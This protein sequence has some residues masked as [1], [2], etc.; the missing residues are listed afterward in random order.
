MNYILVYDLGTS[1]NKASLFSVE[2]RMVKSVVVSYET[3]YLDEISVEQN[4]DDWWKSVIEATKL[5]VAD[6]NVE[7][8]KVISVSGHMQGMVLL[9]D[10]GDL[11]YNSLIWMDQRS[12]KQTKELES[13]ISAERIREITNGGVSP[14][15]TLEKLMWM[16]DEKPEIYKRISKVLNTKDYITYKLTGALVTDFSDGSGTGV[17]DIFNGCWSQEILDVVDIPI[18]IFPELHESIDVVGHVTKEAGEAC[19]IMSGI[20]VVCGG[21]DGACATLGA[22]SIKHGDTYC[23]M[24]SSAQIAITSDFLIVDRKNPIPSLPHV[25]PGK[26]IPIGAMTSA[27]IAYQWGLDLFAKVEKLQAEDMG[28]SVHELVEE[29]VGKVTLGANKLVFLPYLH[30]ERSPRNNPDARGVFFG[31]TSNHT[32]DDMLRAILEGIAFNLGRILDHLKGSIDIEKVNLVG[33]GASS[34]QQKILAD[35]FGLP[36]TTVENSRSASAVGAAVIA[37][38]G[39]GIYEDFD[40]V[41]KF[42]RLKET[43]IPK[44]ADIAAYAPFK[45]IFDQVYLNLEKV[46]KLLL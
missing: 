29:K 35:V 41:F 46:Y 33:G 17:L 43:Y 37:G 42:I 23:L 4:P 45:E 44:D 28:V 31:L 30:G 22:G 40:A 27:G 9:D 34:L 1:G 20:P 26:F 10:C 12:G 13:K 2:G 39:A 3:Y 6:I 25:I 24:G 15:F 5:L 32:T 36:V 18:E 38:V 19:S 8:I 7:D 16:R 21:G 14:I 11:L